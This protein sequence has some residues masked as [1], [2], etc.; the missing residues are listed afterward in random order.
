LSALVSGELFWFSVL[1]VSAS[2]FFHRKFV[3]CFRRYSILY[4][5][6]L[7]SV[8]FVVYVT[9]FLGC[10]RLRRFLFWLFVAGGFVTLEVMRR[11]GD[12]VVVAANVSGSLVGVWR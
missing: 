8:M 6:F 9:V 3:G 7:S 1:V 5:L 2:W 12:A 10:V 4:F 11:G